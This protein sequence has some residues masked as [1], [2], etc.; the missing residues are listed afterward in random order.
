MLLSF[1]AFVSLGLPDGL[2]GVVWPQVSRSFQV[3]LSVLPLVQVAMVLGFQVASLSAYRLSRRLGI[4]RMLALC[5]LVSAASLALQ[6]AAPAFVFFVLVSSG[7]GL[8][9]GAIDASM[10][11]YAARHYS[12]SLL[13]WLHAFYGVGAALG[14]FVASAILAAG[15]GWRVSLLT[16]AAALSVFALFFVWRRHHWDEPEA[17]G[18]TAAADPSARSDDPGHTAVESKVPLREHLGLL[19]FLVYTGVEVSL[20]VWG[21][22]YYHLGL[23]EPE[24]ATASAAGMYWFGLTIGR[25]AFAIVLAYVPLGIILYTGLSG[26]ALTITAMVLLPGAPALL[27][28]PLCGLFL[29]PIFPLLV[30]ATDGRVAPNL[31]AK[32]VGRQIAA[33]N[34]GSVIVPLVGGAIV[35]VSGATGLLWLFVGSTAVLVVAIA[36]IVRQPGPG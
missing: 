34:L 1:T 22:S 15:Y 3:P 23:G 6:T 26:L 32:I 25:M 35:A 7:L 9:G 18:G 2:L 31:V 13:N 30:K 11:A 36:A 33:A 12:P 29:A 16:V 27:M 4:G 24:V 19:V 17:P 10:N 21:F 14:P 28:L 5:A 8:G 20:G